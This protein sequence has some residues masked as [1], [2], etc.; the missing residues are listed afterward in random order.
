MLEKEKK[1]FRGW[2]EIL[3]FNQNKKEKLKKKVN[4]GWIEIMGIK[5]N[6]NRIEKVD[7]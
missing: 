3:V 1:L 5:K 2:I 7:L 4:W 6:W